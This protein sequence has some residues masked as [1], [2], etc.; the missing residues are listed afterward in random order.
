MW[1]GKNYLE[2][3]RMT[4]HASTKWLQIRIQVKFVN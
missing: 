4:V 3:L 1:L 2:P